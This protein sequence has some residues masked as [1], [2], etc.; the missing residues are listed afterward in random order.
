MLY[1]GGKIY[2]YLLVTIDHFISNMERVEK[3][4]F[5]IE[6]I[7]GKIR[8]VTQRFHAEVRQ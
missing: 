4:L 2:E 7:N 6:I 3:D 8:S 1:T 5:S